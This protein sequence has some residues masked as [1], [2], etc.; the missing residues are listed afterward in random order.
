MEKR[1]SVLSYTTS[2][3]WEDTPLAYRSEN[4]CVY[5]QSLGVRNTIIR[6]LFVDRKSQE[7][8]WQDKTFRNREWRIVW[9]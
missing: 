2:P 6:L 3:Q 8:L 5:K 9:S 4:Q 7:D 1:I